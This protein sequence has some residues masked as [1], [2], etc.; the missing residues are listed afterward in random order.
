MTRP[1][2]KLGGRKFIVTLLAQGVNA[3]LVLTGAISDQVYATVF[4]VSV[5][6]YIAGNVAQHISED[7]HGGNHVASTQTPG[8]HPRIG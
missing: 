1:T 2:D 6:A 7:K 4:I 8:Q 3:A 5:G